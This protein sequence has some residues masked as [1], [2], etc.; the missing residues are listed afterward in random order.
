MPEVDLVKFNKRMT[1][2]KAEVA[3]KCADDGEFRS[4]L[5]ADPAATLEKE[6]GLPAGSFKDTKFRVV[7]EGGDEI[8]IPTPAN[9]EDMELSPDQLEA[10]AG[11]VAFGAS[12]A[13]ATFAGIAVGVSVATT[14]VTVAQG[15]RAGREW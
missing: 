11:G 15:T 1:E 4:S 3:A 9:T 12:V 6:Y 10:V 2:V 8:M 7:V 5:V 13:A 14:A